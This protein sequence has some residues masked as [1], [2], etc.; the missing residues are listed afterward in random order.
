MNNKTYIDGAILEPLP[1]GLFDKKGTLGIRIVDKNY[2]NGY[3]GDLTT[4]QG[5]VYNFGLCI[6]R[7]LDLL[8]NFEDKYNIIKISLENISFLDFDMNIE[9]KNKIVDI[10]FNTMKK[11]LENIS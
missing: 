11:Y 2:N 1:I 10:G 8:N 6:K 9:T 7:R 5:F 4:L 3:M